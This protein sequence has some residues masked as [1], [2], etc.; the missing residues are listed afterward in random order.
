MA[1]SDVTGVLYEALRMK[2]RGMAARGRSAG[3]A[4]AHGM[5]MMMRAMMLA[6]WRARRAL[7]RRLIRA[8]A[9]TLRSVTRCERINVFTRATYLRCR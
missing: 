4:S 9:E 3:E 6:C 5:E 7:A 8:L 1:R 2:M